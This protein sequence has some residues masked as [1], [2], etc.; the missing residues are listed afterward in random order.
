[1]WHIRSIRSIGP[2][3]PVLVLAVQ[4]SLAAEPDG[5]SA[6]QQP[7]A[8]VMRTIQIGTP[9]KS[10]N[11]PDAWRQGTFLKP[12]SVS[13]VDVSDDGRFVGVTTM[14]FRQDRNFWLLTDD[15]KV[16][17]GR[18]VEP[19][20]PFQAAVLPQ[21][22]GFGV[23]L[24]YSRVTDPSPTVS[25]FQGEKSE[26]TALVDNIWDMGWLRYGQG[27]WRKGWPASLLGDLIV[28]A[29]NSVFT[30]FS[31]DGAWRLQS[32]GS[33]QK[34]PLR[35]QRPFRMTASADGRVTAYGL[36]V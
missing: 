25:L 14:A 28:R 12:Q 15:G 4:A 5:D 31:N 20:A 2:C 27:D 7:A 32:D 34:Y 33:R 36:L 6:A 21:G 11:V 19:W 10:S 35:N 9:V 30:V 29:D 1:M 17:W 8:P 24:A 16:S 22:K 3:L 23:G 18:Y 26:E 13:A